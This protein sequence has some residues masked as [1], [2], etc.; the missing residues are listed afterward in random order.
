MHLKYFFQHCQRIYI[1]EFGVQNIGNKIDIILPIRYVPSST[2]PDIYFLAADNIIQFSHK[3]LKF[4]WISNFCLWPI[5]CY[6]I[7]LFFHPPYI[8]DAVGTFQTKLHY[9]ENK[10]QMHQF[11]W[12]LFIF[13]PSIVPTFFSPHVPSSGSTYLPSEL[14]IKIGYSW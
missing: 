12:I 3:Y 14:C 2:S 7:N 5:F 8:T 9:M 10:Q 6:N 1:S 4:H 13:H 11:L